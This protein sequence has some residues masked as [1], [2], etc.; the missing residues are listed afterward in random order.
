M[1][2][3][4]TRTRYCDRCKQ[5]IVE[6]GVAHGNPFQ[7]WSTGCVGTLGETIDYCEPC[8]TRLKAFHAAAL[9]FANTH[10]AIAAKRATM[11]ITETEKVVVTTSH[12][13]V[14]F[15]ELTDDQ[16]PNKVTLKN[17]RMC[18]YWSQSVRGIVG[19]AA[20]GP[21]KHCKVTLAAPSITL[22][23]ITSVMKCSDE[24]IK[25]WEAGSWS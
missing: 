4:T 19:L 5:R 18:V 8:S 23:A 12:R 13:G 10:A 7:P 21:D 14:F 3:V 22:Y 9:G 15:G 17:A 2:T 16:S 6:D 1:S 20:T 11:S 24:A 25:Q